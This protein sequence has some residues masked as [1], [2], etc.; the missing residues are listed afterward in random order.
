MKMVRSFSFVCLVA[1]LATVLVTAA[2][3]SS[4]TAQVTDIDNFDRAEVARTYQTWV[5]SAELVSHGWSGSVDG[6]RAGAVSPQFQAATLGAVNWFRQMAGLQPIIDNAA[7]N[8][9]AQQAA[10]MMHAQNTLSHTPSSSWDCYSAAGAES[11][12]RANLTLGVI[13][14]R[15]V[16]GQMEDP[17]AGNT[18]LGHR[19]WLLYPRLDVV[20]VGSTSR[21]G[22]VE[23]IGNFT[24]AQQESPWVAWPPPGYVPDEVLFERWSLSR[25]GADFSRSSVSVT[26]NGQALSVSKLPIANGFGDPALGWEVRNMPSAAGR[27]V[28]YQ[29]TVSNIVVNGQSQTHSY[30]VHAFDP[31]NAV[32]TTATS[33][34]R[35][36][37]EG[38]VATIVGTAGN[39]VLVG[40]EGRDVI[41]G[42]AGHDTI[43]G[44]GGNDLICGG[45]GRDTIEGNAGQDAIYGNG[46]R[47]TLNG[48]AGIDQVHGGK[49]KDTV[50]GGTGQDTLSGG[51]GIDV[52]DGNGAADTCWYQ[53]VNKP[54]LRAE[55]ATNCERVG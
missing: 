43:R 48:N 32:A 35:P 46:G 9:R 17:G 34:A 51:L 28:T 49:G 23:V 30:T 18:A 2:T 13:G 29:V 4:A 22:V 40:T 36:T 27:D 47:D 12:G 42:L 26:A 11:A 31:D 19:R 7:A 8:N 53:G 33:A 54:A 16:T 24:A 3:R 52:L 25:A 6:C 20:G 44:L 15:G 37:C 21:A 14:S 39:D 10:L 45:S 41:V 50:E 38:V 1:L 55:T 5:E